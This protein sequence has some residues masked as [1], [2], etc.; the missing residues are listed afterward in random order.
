MEMSNIKKVTINLQIWLVISIVFVSYYSLKIAT[1][2][3][4]AQRMA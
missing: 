3:I 2:D 4:F 1:S